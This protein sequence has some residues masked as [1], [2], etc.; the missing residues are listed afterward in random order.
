MIGTSGG[1]NGV[2]DAHISLSRCLPHEHTQ[3]H[4]SLSSPL[5]VWCMYVCACM[6]ESDSG[7]IGSVVVSVE[8]G[9]GLI[10]FGGGLSRPEF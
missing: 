8:L 1:S 3:H 4:T 9:D 5:Y 6:D 10:V 2:G 7:L